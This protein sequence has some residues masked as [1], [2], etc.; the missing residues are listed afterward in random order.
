MKMWFDTAGTFA[1]LRATGKAKIGGFE[2]MIESIER[3]V[4]KTNVHVQ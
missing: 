3:K 2:I 1:P 4:E